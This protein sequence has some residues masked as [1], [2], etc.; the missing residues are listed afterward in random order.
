LSRWSDDVI[1][2]FPSIRALVDRMRAPFTEDAGAPPVCAEVQLSA[3][4]AWSGGRIAVDVP[5][6]R[7]CRAC[8]GRGEIREEPCPACEGSGD[9]VTVEPV[10]VFVP[11]GVRDGAVFRLRVSAAAAQTAVD[12]R[13]R[14]S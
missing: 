9:R 5:L 13:V 6:R 3:R 10:H 14:V 7:P 8:R 4:D 11:S 2:D 12:L 1:V